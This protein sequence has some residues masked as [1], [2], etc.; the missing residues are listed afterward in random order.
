MDVVIGIGIGIAAGALGGLFGIGGGLVMIPSMIYFLG[1]SQHM[2]QGTSLAA[3]V[4]PIGFLAAM[5]YHRK[6]FVNL[7]VAFSIALAF[8]VGS[9]VSAKF[10]M[11]LDGML[12][13]RLFAVLLAVVAVKMFIGK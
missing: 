8:V 5:E 13:K 4:L 10:A 11:K 6:G 3:M 9:Y 1:Y 7:P 12:M 2:A